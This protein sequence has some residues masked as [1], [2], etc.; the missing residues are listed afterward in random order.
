MTRS[1]I[2]DPIVI[3]AANGITIT[4]IGTLST[5]YDIP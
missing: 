1:S 3:M 4:V 2:T 5:K